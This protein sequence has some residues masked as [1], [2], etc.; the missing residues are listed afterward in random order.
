MNNRHDYIDEINRQIENAAKPSWLAMHWEGFLVAFLWS[1]IALF[2]LFSVANSQETYDARGTVNLNGVDVPFAGE[3][4]LTKKPVGDDDDDDDDDDGPP[5]RG[6][7]V[8]PDGS[9]QDA[10]TIA[11]PFKTISRALE[12]GAKDRPIFLQRGGVWEERNRIRNRSGVHIKAYGDGKAPVIDGKKFR[13]GIPPG[14]TVTGPITE[15]LIDFYTCK[16]CSI[17]GI[18]FRNAPYSGVFI[19]DRSE[20]ITV[21]S[22][23]F[24]QIR[25]SSVYS[26]CPKGR[27]NKKHS[28]VAE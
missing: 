28:S 16:D 4:M 8:A 20:N 10:G 25:V 18:E 5:P 3:L 27:E 22:C 23:T 17:K 2:L 26:Y 12:M 14:E 9:D 15:G 6:V 13:V 21:E 19:W 1:L 24:D 7:Y 11:A